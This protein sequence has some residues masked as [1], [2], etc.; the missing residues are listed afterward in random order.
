[1]SDKALRGISVRRR[2]PYLTQS[3]F[4]VTFTQESGAQVWGEPERGGI[5]LHFARLGLEAVADAFERWTTPEANQQCYRVDKFKLFR[6]VMGQLTLTNKNQQSSNV[7][8]T[9]L[10]IISVFQRLPRVLAGLK[11][12]FQGSTLLAFGI[13]ENDP[14]LSGTDRSEPAIERDVNGVP[15]IRQAVMTPNNFIHELGHA[16]TGFAGFKAKYL[17]SVEYEIATANPIPHNDYGREGMG[18]PELRANLIAGNFDT[19]FYEHANIVPSINNPQEAEFQPIAPPSNYQPTGYLMYDLLQTKFDLWDNPNYNVYRFI[20]RNARI[21]IFVQNYPY[22][23]V[24][25][26]G[27]E[28]TARI[29]I[30]A[31]SFLN[32][33][34]DSFIYDPVP[35]QKWIDFFANRIGLFLRNGAMYH[36]GSLLHYQTK[37]LVQ[38]PIATGNPIDGY[39]LRT[40]PAEETDNRNF[41]DFSQNLLNTQVNVYGWTQVV[42]VKWL[43]VE[44][45]NQR[46]LW[47]A[48]GGITNLS[49][50]LTDVNKI[51][52]ANVSDFY[53]NHPYEASD[54]NT[55]LGIV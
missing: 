46:L 3:A 36:Y 28:T 48:E 15:I 42:S 16:F 22:R 41:F 49:N 54:L 53:L 34:R 44:D 24:Q 31:D 13:P 30:A 47:I 14:C 37:G 27:D 2:M 19:L 10:S 50:A 55:I 32:W 6:Q 35:G 52:D 17:G 21:D 1:M 7:A 12:C 39:K 4:G 45:N 40:T 9:G 11:D 23:P 8:E 29:E 20:N 43:L 25:D 18:L 26:G 33:V 51:P 38:N 5:A